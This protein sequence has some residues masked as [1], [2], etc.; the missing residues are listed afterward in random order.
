MS[1]RRLRARPSGVSLESMGTVSARPTTEKRVRL[2]SKVPQKFS[3]TAMARAQESSQL[4]LNFAVKAIVGD[5]EHNAFSARVLLQPGEHRLVVGDQRLFDE[6]V[7]AMFDEIVEQFDLGRVGNAEQRRVV[8]V[9]GNLA[10]IP[11]IGVG[12]AYVD[13]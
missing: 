10:Q 5:I 13:G 8:G 9:E 11:K 2:S 4:L 3:S 7:L 6:S 1:T 12:I